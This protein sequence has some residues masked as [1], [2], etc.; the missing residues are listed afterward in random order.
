MICE[1]V[2]ALQ[3]RAHAIYRF[4]FGCKN[5]FFKLKTEA[6]LTSTHNLCFGAKIKKTKNNRYNPAYT[7]FAIQKW[8]LRGYSLHGYVRMMVSS[9]QWYLMTSVKFP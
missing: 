9:L 3:K 6:V 7:S 8:G 1:N 2:F 5:D 4:F